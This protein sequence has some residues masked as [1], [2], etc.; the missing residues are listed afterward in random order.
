M[1]ADTA[2]SSTRY[3]AVAWTI[4]ALASVYAF[5]QDIISPDWPAFVLA[6]LLVAGFRGAVSAAPSDGLTRAI[7]Y[8]AALLLVPFMGI[9]GLA[10]AA[11]S[12]EWPAWVIAPVSVAILWIGVA[13]ISEVEGE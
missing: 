12:A 4:V 7:L 3:W 6:P 2:H 1:M 10:D 5:L 13:T 8:Q 11:F 9:Y